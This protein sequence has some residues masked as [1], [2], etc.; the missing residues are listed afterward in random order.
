MLCPNC[1]SELV[2]VNGRYICSECGKEVPLNEVSVGASDEADDKLKIKPTTSP[3]SDLKPDALVKQAKD[4]ISID[5]SNVVQGEVMS[6]TVTAPVVPSDNLENK[7]STTSTESPVTTDNFDDIDKEVFGNNAPAKPVENPEIPQA[8]ERGALEVEGADNI[9]LN[10]TGEDVTLNSEIYTD[11]IYEKASTKESISTPQSKIVGSKSLLK[12]LDADPAKESKLNIIILA[13]GG[14]LAVVFIVVGMLAFISLSGKA[15]VPLINGDNI[16]DITINCDGAGA[17][18]KS[19]CIAENFKSCKPAK[20][21][22]D[23]PALPDTQVSYKIVGLSDNLCQVDITMN[24]YVDRPETENKTM[25]C[26]LALD[27]TFED[28]LSTI[29]NVNCSGSLA[30]LIYDSVSPTPSI[31]PSVTPTATPTN[32]PVPVE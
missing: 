4:N 26:R 30:N 28:G 18:S 5:T 31:T 1:K 20:W 3:A 2:E 17:D 23:F 10:N 11:P 27:K 25:S 13:V 29:S 32:S 8:Y 14:L 24:K 16:N 15:K 21:S 12:T 19:Q 6:E 7:Q 22:G 9:D